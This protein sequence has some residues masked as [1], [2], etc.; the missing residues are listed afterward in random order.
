[1]NIVIGYLATAKAVWTQT[2]RTLSSLANTCLNPTSTT[3]GVVAAGTTV[4]FRPT[5][6]WLARN[7]T[8]AIT[9]GA[10]N[11]AN[12]ALSD[13]T[14]SFVG[15]T[16]PTGQTRAFIWDTNSSVGLFVINTDVVNNATFA[17][18]TIDWK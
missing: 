15:G 4:D 5:G 8:I 16:S 2:I 17:M 11:V 10:A 14:N 6:G 1:V 7:I 12:V 3:V 13:G 9:A 18:A